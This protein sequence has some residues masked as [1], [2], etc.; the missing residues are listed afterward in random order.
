MESDNQQLPLNDIYNWFRDRST[1]FRNN[2]VTWKVQKVKYF[3]VKIS[4]FKNAIRH[5]LS[6][7]KYFKRVQTNKGSAWVVD[8]EEFMKRKYRKTRNSFDSHQSSA[9][10]SRSSSPRSSVL[11]LREDFESQDVPEDLSISK[12]GLKQAVVI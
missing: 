4:H 3:L 7:H 2:S 1:Y 11:I 6:L 8:E 9:D 12:L 10:C 5:N